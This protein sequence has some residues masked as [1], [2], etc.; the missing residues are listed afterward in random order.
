[1]KQKV[2]KRKS[3]SERPALIK[4]ASEPLKPVATSKKIKAERV[5]SKTGIV[6]S[7]LTVLG[8][9]LL[10]IK[11]FVPS[12]EDPWNKGALLINAAAKENNASEKIRL[13]SDAHFILSKTITAHP[14][15]ARVWSIYG[16]YFLQKQMWDSAIICEKKAIELGQGGTVN[17]VEF[18]A[19]N[20]LSYAVSM[21]LNKEGANDALYIRNVLKNAEVPGFENYELIKM[22]GANYT[23]LNKPD[24]ALY[25]LYKA[26]AIER[27]ADVYF[28][29]ALNYVKKNQRDSAIAHL[30]NCLG[31]KKDY[32]PAQ[33]L[34][35]QISTPAK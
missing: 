31:L 6:L 17:R 23:N 32:Q 25:F 1:M 7:S 30:K 15:H 20:A 11:A 26:V 10:W 12:V 3:V 13:L 19:G 18:E 29:I 24:S 4:A 2:H 9:F 5:N 27:D 8:F 16:Y 33:Q 14:Y 21:K 35:Q 34:L 28:N 22:Q